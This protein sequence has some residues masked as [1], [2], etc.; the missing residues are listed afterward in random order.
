MPSSEFLAFR[1]PLFVVSMLCLLSSFAS[2]QIPAQID[3]V[4]DIPWSSEVHAFE[5]AD[6]LHPPHRGSVVFVGSSSIAR[7]PDLSNAYPGISVVQ[8][9]FGGAE[10]A[11][12]VYYAPRIVIRYAPHVVVV[13]AG[14]NDLAN[15]KSP[16]DIL[17]SFKELVKLVHASLPTTRIAFVS[18]KPSLARWSMSDSIRA[19]NRLVKDFVASD[20]RLSYVDIFTAMLGTGGLPRPDLFDRDSLHMNAAGYKIWKRHIEPVVRD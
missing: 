2:A 3:S 1:Y 5:A 9:G 4:E 8:R 18:I 6:R 17:Q 16:Q 13:Y 11:Q 19:T 20:E 15:G 10:M 12:V 7:W 14:D